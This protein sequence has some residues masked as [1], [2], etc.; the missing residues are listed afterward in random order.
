MDDPR[1]KN[2]ASVIPASI[3]KQFEERGVLENGEFTEFGEF[4]INFMRAFID[5]P[6]GFERI[7]GSGKIPS[8]FR[9]RRQSKLKY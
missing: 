4:A 6:R 2:P 3:K 9:D 1:V 5:D 7:I 8:T